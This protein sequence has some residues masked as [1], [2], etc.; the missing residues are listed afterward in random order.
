MTNVAI[1]GAGIG[2]EHLTGYLA[3]A[4]S[5]RVT[6]ICDRDEAR[7]LPL[8]KASGARVV[9][10]IDRVLADPS[11]DLIDICL[12]PDLHVPVALKALGCG[13]HV[14]VEKPIAGSVVEA[15][16]LVRAA[17]AS[18]R[19]IFPVFQYR[20]GP[21]FRALGALNAAGFLGKPQVATLETHWNRGAEYYAVPWRGTWAHERGGAVL[22]H[23][24]HAH[25]LICQLFGPVASVSAEV[26]TRI[27]PI[28]TEDCAAIALRMQ[29]GALVTSSIT[30]G[31]AEN[32][33]RLRLVYE[34]VTVESARV[35]YDPAQGTWT[36][37]ARAE[38]DQATID[39]IT[40]TAPSSEPDG[41]V[42]YLAAVAAALRGED[43]AAVSLSDGVASI[44]LVSA[45][46]HAAR[47]GQ[48]VCLPLD[49]TLP[50]CESLAP[51]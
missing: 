2:R 34:K 11:V 44:E 3:L 36:F 37:R 24:I 19:S 50:I 29:N 25:D 12:P 17:S 51:T 13:K 40:A 21:A 46:Y 32:T 6:V 20:Y 39:E 26:A 43:G 22:G 38:A 5:F 49:R 27:N 7:A 14:V 10:D 41:F 4:D 35:P 15:D 47:T 33:S 18:D 8:A 45:I 1:L 16:R 42:G 48:R 28:E 9:S 23:A 31:A 30:L